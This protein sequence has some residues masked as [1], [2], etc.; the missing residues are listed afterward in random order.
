MWKWSFFSKNKCSW[1]FK[2]YLSYGIR[3]SLQPSRIKNSLAFYDFSQQ[4]LRIAAKLSQDSKMLP[5]F[6]PSNKNPGDLHLALA[7]VLGLIDDSMSDEEIKNQR[8]I[9]NEYL[10]APVAASSF[11]SFPLYL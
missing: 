3:S 7:K 9:I 1:T 2:D 4:E 5:F 10:R 11:L 8:K 6:S